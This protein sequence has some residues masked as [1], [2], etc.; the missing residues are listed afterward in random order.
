[1]FSLYK[2]IVIFKLLATYVPTLFT[3]SV[4]VVGRKLGGAMGESIVCSRVGV[5]KLH[6]GP[7]CLVLLMHKLFSL[8]M[9]TEHLFSI[10]GELF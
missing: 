9:H 5:K 1:M 10:L 3:P 4:Q 8:L 6:L 7:N 2:T